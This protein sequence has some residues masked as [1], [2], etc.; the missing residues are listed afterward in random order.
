M[1]DTPADVAAGVRVLGVATGRTTT[2][3]LDKAGATAFIAV[4]EDL[5]P[6]R[7]LLR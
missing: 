1:G 6:L 3:E 7:A 4:L 2:A 5:R